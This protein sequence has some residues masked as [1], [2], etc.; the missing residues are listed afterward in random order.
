MQRYKGSGSLDSTF[1]LPIHA[2]GHVVQKHLHVRPP[3]DESPNT[4]V[5]TPLL[6]RSLISEPGARTLEFNFPSFDQVQCL[7]IGKEVLGGLPAMVDPLLNKRSRLKCDGM[8][9]VHG[10][11]PEATH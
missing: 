4:G 9:M 6:E 11:L 2:L 5:P 1:F 10:Q 8:A 3:V 7:G